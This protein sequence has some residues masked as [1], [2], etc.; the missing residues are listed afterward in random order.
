MVVY[1]VEKLYLDR[2]DVRKPSDF[3]Y[4]IYLA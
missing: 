4:L 3:T 1:N 2:L